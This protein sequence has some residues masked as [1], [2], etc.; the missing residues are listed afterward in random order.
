MQRVMICVEMS[1]RPPVSEKVAAT[2]KAN[3]KKFRQDVRDRVN[4]V[5]VPSD[6]VDDGGWIEPDGIRSTVTNVG[7]FLLDGLEAFRRL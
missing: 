3:V 7:R 5:D 2:I 6:S 4:W 1:D